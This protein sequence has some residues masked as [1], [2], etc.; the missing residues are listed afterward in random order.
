MENT[1]NPDTIEQNLTVDK[2]MSRVQAAGWGG[3]SM[4]SFFNRR[5]Q[6]W[7]FMACLIRDNGE[8]DYETNLWNYTDTAVQALVQIVEKAERMSK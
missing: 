6:A 2:A 5:K 4:W 8:P 1:T 3:L 7:E